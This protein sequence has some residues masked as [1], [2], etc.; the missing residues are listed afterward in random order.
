M[1]LSETDRP[2]MPP[3]PG[4]RHMRK[5]RFR[6]EIPDQLLP[7]G[8]VVAAPVLEQRAGVERGADAP[9]RAAVVA[10]TVRSETLTASVAKQASLHTKRRVALLIVILVSASV[11]ILVLSLLLAG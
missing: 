1:I 7:G 9:K 3:T 11:P 5:R 8:P 10:P 4:P 2:L 6:R